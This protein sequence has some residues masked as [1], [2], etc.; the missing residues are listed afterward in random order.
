MVALVLYF[1]LIVPMN[2]A[3]RRRGETASAPT[4]NELLAEIRDLLREQRH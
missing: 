2:A 1:I 3:K 4:D